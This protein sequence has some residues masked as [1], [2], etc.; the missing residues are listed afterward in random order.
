MIR[1]RH[2][3][4]GNYAQLLD[5]LSDLVAPLVMMKLSLFDRNLKL[6]IL[7]KSSSEKFENPRKKKPAQYK[8]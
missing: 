3:I 2:I 7:L 6:F 1:I 4:P 5:R 8:L